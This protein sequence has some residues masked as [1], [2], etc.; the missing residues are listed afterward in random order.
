MRAL[1][2]IAATAIAAA[3]L[4][5]TLPASAALAKDGDGFA[6][7]FQPE[8]S[9][10]PAP[11]FRFGRRDG[12]RDI[13]RRRGFG[14]VVYLDREYQGDTA[15]RSDSFNDWWHERPN[16]AYPAWMQRNHD[17]QRQW[18]EGDTLRC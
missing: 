5:T 10:G 9:L 4:A 1:L 17:C 8:S 11:D 2:P 13:R 12:D 14:D 18:F 3:T 7:S 6:F 16:R 15:W